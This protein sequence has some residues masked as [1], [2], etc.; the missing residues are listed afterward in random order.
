MV[1]QMIVDINFT[2]ELKMTHGCLKITDK[3]GNVCYL[4][5]YHTGM[6]IPHAVEAAVSLLATYHAATVRVY[7]G[8]S[9]EE[10]VIGFCESNPYCD[11]LEYGNSIA[12]LIVAVSP[13]FLEPLYD[14]FVDDLAKWSGYDTPY[15][16][17]VKD[18]RWILTNES[19]EVIL[20]WDYCD[21]IIKQMIAE[22]DLDA[23]RYESFLE[24]FQ[25]RRRQ[26]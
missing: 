2:K 5:T 14:C 24:S 9:N 3:Y 15:H 10:K 1:G 19:G 8:D 17:E 25:R 6:D 13:G 12:A 4:H 26:S 16:L 20:N 22:L 23:P 18:E 11:R 7:R 21:E